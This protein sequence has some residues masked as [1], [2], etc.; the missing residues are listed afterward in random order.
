MGRAD[1]VGAVLRAG[2]KEIAGL[3]VDP[4]DP[5]DLEALGLRQNR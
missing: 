3:A 2:H 1:P 4:A 5:A